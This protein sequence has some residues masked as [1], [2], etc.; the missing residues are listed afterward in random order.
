MSACS[1]AAFRQGRPSP[2]VAQV[3]IGARQD[4]FAGERDLVQ[5]QAAAGLPDAQ[6]GFQPVDDAFEFE[7]VR[8]HH[9]QL[10]V[11]AAE[12]LGGVT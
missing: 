6:A 2:A 7:G 12:A 9:M 4:A 11:E 1:V 10:V 3:S 5:H 8:A